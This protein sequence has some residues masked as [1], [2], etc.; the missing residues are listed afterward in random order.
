MNHSQS[1]PTNSVNAPQTTVGTESKPVWQTV[2]I[3]TADKPIVLRVDSPRTLES[4][5][6]LG[7]LIE[8]FKPRLIF[9]KSI[10][11]FKKKKRSDE[12]S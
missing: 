8:Y 4:C 9:E 10:V 5:N 3:P 1:L 6:E 2:S 11:F 7:L 12:I